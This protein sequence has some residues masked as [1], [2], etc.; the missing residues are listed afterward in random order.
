MNFTFNFSSRINLRCKR[1]QKIELRIKASNTE[2]FQLNPE[3]IVVVLFHSPFFWAERLVH[4]INHYR[5]LQ[6]A[7]ECK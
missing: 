2:G 7:D 1:V 3:P 6:A 4:I 5:K